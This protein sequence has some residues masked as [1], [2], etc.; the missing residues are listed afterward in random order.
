MIIDQRNAIILF[1][2][3]EYG[4]TCNVVL[5]PKCYIGMYLMDMVYNFDFLNQKFL[6]KKY[7]C[8]Q[9]TEAMA[10]ICKIFKQSLFC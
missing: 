9:K 10:S 5:C 1:P 3:Y 7:P 2:F 8:P 4:A 6:S